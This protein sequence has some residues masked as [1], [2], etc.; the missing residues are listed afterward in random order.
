MY[1]Y[2][3]SVSCT[4]LQ[5]STSSLFER[6]RIELSVILTVAVNNT[7]LLS[8][9]GLLKGP[10]FSP[11]FLVRFVCIVAT[12]GHA[13]PQHE[14]VKGTK[15]RNRLSCTSKLHF[16]MPKG[17]C[18]HERRQEGKTSSDSVLDFPDQLRHS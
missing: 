16:T 2:S 5:G 10:L 15:D 13:Y 9:L 17:H 3:F 12:E 14:T 6:F 11:A 4:S 8:T 1:C 7:K 18:Y